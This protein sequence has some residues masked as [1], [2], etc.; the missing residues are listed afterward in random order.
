MLEIVL[1]CDTNEGA[2]IRKQSKDKKILNFGYHTIIQ[3]W[4]ALV[5]GRIEKLYMK[6][7][8]Y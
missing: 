4:F 3:L 7:T 1:K 2:K 5:L 8:I 6:L